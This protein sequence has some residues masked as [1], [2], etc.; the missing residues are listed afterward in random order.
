MKFVVEID[1]EATPAA[2]RAHAPRA[3]NE[4]VIA[5]KGAPRTKP[6]ALNVAMPLA[7]GSLVAVF[8]A[9]DVPQPD[10]LR[11]SAA[12]FA[13]LP[14]DIACLQASLVIDNAPE[15][16][17]TALFAMDYAALFDVYNRGLAALGLPLFLGGTSNHFRAIR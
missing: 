13:S 2:L 16:W 11:R 10:Q 9:E 4:I 3:P 6:R 7:R 15:N 12:L 17:M 14:P 8:D 5:P 1:D